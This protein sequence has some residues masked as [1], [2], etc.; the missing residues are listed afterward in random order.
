[1]VAGIPLVLT[2]KE[3]RRDKLEMQSR[4]KQQR[5]WD[6]SH[7][8]LPYWPADVP[9]AKESKWLAARQQWEAKYPEAG[10]LP[11]QGQLG[12]RVSK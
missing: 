6:R 8:D 12:I 3:K 1:L 5:I 2:V 4:A 7:P 9:P 10:H 11:W